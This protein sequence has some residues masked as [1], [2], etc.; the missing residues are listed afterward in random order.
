MFFRPAHTSVN[1]V[2]AGGGRRVPRPLN[3]TR[4]LRTAQVNLLGYGETTPGKSVG[5]LLRYP[6]AAWSFAVCVTT[7]S[8]WKITA[9]NCSPEFVALGRMWPRNSPS[10]LPLCA[11]VP[12]AGKRIGPAGPLLSAPKCVLDVTDANGKGPAILQRHGKCQG[13][14]LD[15]HENQPMAPT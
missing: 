6:A 14:S 7:H 12:A 9:S 10:S 4:H 15:A 11:F 5:R 1:I 13:V 2:V 8:I 3:D